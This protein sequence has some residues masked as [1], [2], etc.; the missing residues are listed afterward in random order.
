MSKPIDGEAVVLA[1]AAAGATFKL[2]K[3]LRDLWGGV[4]GGLDATDA[5]YVAYSAAQA[6]RMASDDILAEMPK[7]CSKCGALKGTE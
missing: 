7:V 1:K 2:E 6:V 4:D 5:T 3:H